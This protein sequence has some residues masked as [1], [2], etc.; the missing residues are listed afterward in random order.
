MSLWGLQRIALR[1]SSWFAVGTAQLTSNAAG[2]VIPGGGAASGAFSYRMLVQAGIPGGDV[3][4][5]LTA[6]MLATTATVFALPL[7]ALPAV[8]GGRGAARARRDGVHRRRRIRARRGSRYGGL[9]VG[10]PAVAR[11]PRRTLG[12]AAHVEARQG[13]RPAGTAAA[14]A[15][16]DSE[17][18]RRALAPRARGR[19]GQGRL[20]LH[21]AR[22]LPRRRRRAAESVARAARLRR[23]GAARARPRDA[24][25]ARLRRGGADGLLALA[26]VSAE[27]A[28]V[29]T[30]AYRLV[31]FWLP[32]PVGGIAYLLFRRRYGS[33][34]DSSASTASP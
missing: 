8:L 18:I 19:G 3:A 7:L 20:R 31:S 32:L 22:L 2:S 29:A 21:R 27:Q 26:G 33:A 34:G 30:L 24:G 5:G 10:P 25:R 13:G 9:P 11:R 15:R 4:A 16:P 14:P 17:R 12:D 1:T 28:I 23:G 6:T